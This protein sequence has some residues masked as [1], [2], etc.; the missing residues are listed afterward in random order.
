MFGGVV[1]VL[2]FSGPA[3][4][5]HV[6]HKNRFPSFGVLTKWHYVCQQ[7]GRIMYFTIWKYIDDLEQKAQLVKKYRIEPNA[8]GEQVCHRQ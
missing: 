2:Q 4:Y 5:M 8:S 6:F 7:A 3:K 1:Q